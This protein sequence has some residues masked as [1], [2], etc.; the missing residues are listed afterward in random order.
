MRP[1]IVYTQMFMTLG[2]LLRGEFKPDKKNGYFI[3]LLLFS[4]IIVPTLGLALGLAIM[5]TII[6]YV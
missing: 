6:I 5:M 1:R 4:A 2:Q 3:I